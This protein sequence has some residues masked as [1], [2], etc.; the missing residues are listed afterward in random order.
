MLRSDAPELAAVGADPGH[1]VTAYTPLI[2]LH[3]SQTYLKAAV[4]GPAELVFFA[5]AV[6]EISLP[7]F[8][9]QFYRPFHR[10]YFSS[11]TS[12]QAGIFPL[13][14]TSISWIGIKISASFLTR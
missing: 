8:P 10:Q 5:A 9:S 12:C 1:R 14:P 13:R 6:A 11:G 4:A 3:T 7:F 2:L